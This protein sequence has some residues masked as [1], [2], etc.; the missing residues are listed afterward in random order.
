MIF[1]HQKKYLIEIKILLIL[2]K[3]ITQSELFFN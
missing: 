3:L 2:K 1:K